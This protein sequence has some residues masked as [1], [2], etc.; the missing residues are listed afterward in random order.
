MLSAFEMPKGRLSCLHG[1]GR[2]GKGFIG[3][4]YPCELADGEQVEYPRAPNIRRN[5]LVLAQCEK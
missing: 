4:S 1:A 2:H 5:L 3:Y